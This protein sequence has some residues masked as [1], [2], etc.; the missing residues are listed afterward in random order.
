MA[1]ARR[2]WQGH[3]LT[4]AGVLLT[5]SGWLVAG[6]LGMQSLQDDADL[7]YRMGRFG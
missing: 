5:A 6:G 2:R 1:K 3:R 4:L 7:Y